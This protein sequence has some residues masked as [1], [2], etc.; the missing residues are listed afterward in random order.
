MNDF[1]IGEFCAGISGFGLGFEQAGWHTTWQVE[2]DDVN[3]AC[4]ADRFPDARQFKNLL[5]WRRFDL[6]PVACVCFGSPCQ[7]ISVMGNSKRDKSRHGLDGGRSG[8]FFAIM[9]AVAEL[10]P[11]WIVFE[12]VPALINSNGG[13]DLQAVIGTFAECGYLGC[14]RVLDAQYFG[15][16]Q[17]RRRLV[18]VA[19]LGRKPPPEFMADAGTMESLP[20]ALREEQECR[21]GDSWAGYTLTAPDKYNGC[22]SRTN[23]GSETFVAEEDG[24]NSMVE[25]GREVELHGLPAGLDVQNTEQAYAAG[26]AFPPPMARWVAE[27]LKRA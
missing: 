9:E 12:N 13:R 23:L 3:R 25:R 16:P 26:N 18:M 8:L 10:R 15:M 14:G 24:W 22:S 4:L 6:S 7:D 2:L 21:R 27:I 20:C 11:E 5:D 1:T 17:K 19:G